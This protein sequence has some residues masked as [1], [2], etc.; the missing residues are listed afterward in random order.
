MAG[1]LA[2]KWDRKYAELH[3]VYPSPLFG[4]LVGVYGVE[5]GQRVWND[6]EDGAGLCGMVG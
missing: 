5:G 3:V 2:L 1:F 4:G 6:F